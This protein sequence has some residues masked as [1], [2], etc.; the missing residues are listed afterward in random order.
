MAPMVKREDSK[1]LNP[2]SSADT[3][4]PCALRPRIRDFHE[5]AL[6]CK[7]SA[8]VKLEPIDRPDALLA[9]IL[10]KQQLGINLDLCQR[11]RTLQGTTPLSPSSILAKL[12]SVSQTRLN[13]HQVIF[14]S[15]KKN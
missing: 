5:R 14:K 9:Q 6:K 2:S 3:S 1:H 8:N 15:A 13:Q 11:A 12:S 7:I 4:I 10:E